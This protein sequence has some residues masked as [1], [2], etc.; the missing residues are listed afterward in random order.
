MAA[1][2]DLKRLKRH[3]N[4]MCVPHVNSDSNKPIVK[5]RKDTLGKFKYG[6]GI[7]WH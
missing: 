2:K 1:G 6:L 7:K 5:I 3:N 4:Q